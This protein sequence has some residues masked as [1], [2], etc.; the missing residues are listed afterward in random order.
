[1][2]IYRETEQAASTCDSNSPP[3]PPDPAAE[4][5]AFVRVGKTWERFNLTYDT[6]VSRYVEQYRNTS[7]IQL[8]AI[9]EH[10]HQRP[11][12]LTIVLTKSEGTVVLPSGNSE[13]RSVTLKRLDDEWRWQD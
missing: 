1:M 12:T 3:A 5:V 13:F 2:V 9:I 7:V 6:L 10:E 8:E 11:H 4:S